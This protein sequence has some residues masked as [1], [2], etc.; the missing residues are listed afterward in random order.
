MAIALMNQVPKNKD[1]SLVY[2]IEGLVSSFIVN[3]NETEMENIDAHVASIL[4]NI[5]EKTQTSVYEPERL[6]KILLQDLNF[7]RIHISLNLLYTSGISG[8]LLFSLNNLKQ[9]TSTI[10]IDNDV[11]LINLANEVKISAYITYTLASI[12]HIMTG[13]I[14]IHKNMVCFG[15]EYGYGITPTKYVPHN[16]VLH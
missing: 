5:F 1:V 8:T 16:I 2:P 14:T 9:L 3:A 13:N 6:L 15:T 12:L 4:T 11:E 10:L 7:S